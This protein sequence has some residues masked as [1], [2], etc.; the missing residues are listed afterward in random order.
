MDKYNTADPYIGTFDL[1]TY[2]SDGISKVYAIGFH[3]K[4]N[5]NYYIDKDTL[6]SN[7]LIMRCLKDLV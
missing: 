5:N 2:K 7:E 4:N 1:E 3:T 6:D